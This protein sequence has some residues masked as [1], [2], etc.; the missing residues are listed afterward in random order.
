VAYRSDQLVG[1]AVVNPRGDELGSVDDIVMSPETGAIAYLV[2]ARGGI[3]GFD[4]KYLPV[5]WEDFKIATSNKLLVLD[6]ATATMEA[7]PHVKEDQNFQ[8][9]DF[10]AESHKVDAYWSAHLAPLASAQVQQAPAVGT[11]HD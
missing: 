8:H 1:A 11:A 4:R 10:A 7:A 5:P 2:V 3:F 9:G 6:T